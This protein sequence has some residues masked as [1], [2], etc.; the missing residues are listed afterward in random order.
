MVTLARRVERIPFAPVAA[1]TLSAAAAFLVAATPS[2]LFERAVTASGIAYLLPFASPPLGL[3]ARLLAIVA[4]AALVFL[5]LRLVLGAVERSFMPPRTRGEWHDEGYDVADVEPVV[6]VVPRRRPIFAD[7]EL[8]AP[9]M[10]DAAIGG[11]LAADPLDAPLA[12]EEFA[13][14]DPEGTVPSSGERESIASLIARLEAGLAGRGGG[15]DP[16]AG[17]GASTLTLAPEWM[18]PGDVASDRD[19]D[20][21]SEPSSMR[22]AAA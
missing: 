8:G 11:T 22:Y 21:D 15:G 9:L 19:R 16:G 4:V 1:A 13:V 17:V 6:D 5:V 2:D 14:E 3:T 7:T 18:V 20:D 10:S 12:I